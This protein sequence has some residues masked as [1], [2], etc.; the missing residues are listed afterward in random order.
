[1]PEVLQ[2]EHSLCNQ[3]NNSSLLRKGENKGDV[4]SIVISF[5]YKQ[6]EKLENFKTRHFR[7]SYINKVLFQDNFGVCPVGTSPNLWKFNKKKKKKIGSII[8]L[9]SKVLQNLNL[10]SFYPPSH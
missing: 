5:S 4:C 2:T 6:Y 1:M 9:Y 3:G 7:L 10:I 8:F